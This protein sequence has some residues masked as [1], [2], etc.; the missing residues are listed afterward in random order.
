[1]RRRRS[2][3]LLLVVGLLCAA[4]ASAQ[5]PVRQY[6]L[7]NART[8]AAAG[9]VAHASGFTLAAVQLFVA[10]GSA[11]HA[12]VTFEQA[13]VDSHYSAALCTP[14][15]GGAAHSGVSIM[16][17]NSASVSLHWRCNVSGSNWFRARI[18]AISGGQLSI[19]ATLLPGGSHSASSMSRRWS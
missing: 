13:L 8:S 15:S 17:S 2:S 7:H 11:P 5:L 6:V 3:V 4:P 1:M 19:Y 10:S 14:V 16:P 18:N 12:I 9:N